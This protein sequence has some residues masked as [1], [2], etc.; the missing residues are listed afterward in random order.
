[1]AL[2]QQTRAQLRRRIADIFGD[3]RVIE[4]T[5]NG[6]AS[7]FID[8]FNVNS[9]T[10]EYRK[11]EILFTSGVNAGLASVITNTN[12]TNGTLTFTPSRSSTST[13]DDAEL[14]KIKG[15]GFSLAEYHRAIND[16][17]QELDGI[18]LIDTTQ[19]VALA[20]DA[21]TQTFLV[22]ASIR[23]VYRVEYEDAAGSWQELRPALR[24][25]QMG[26]TPEPGSGSIRV[27]GYGAYA[28]DGMDLR[29]WGYGL[30]EP[31][32]SD[33]S[34]CYYDAKAVVDIAAANLC[35]SRIDREPKYASL[36][37]TLMKRAEESKARARVLRD[38]QSQL[39][40]A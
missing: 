18:A 11:C 19:A 29:V 21:A 6:T 35:T 13:G 8:T 24:A 28:A 20:Y 31:L 30:Q 17:I 4:A 7:T 26:W 22:P 10:E 27:E 16:A 36:L 9:G 12:T 37:L 38:H 25:G 3:L 1:M 40:R 14:Y 15:T 5:A 32:S 39:V 33:A 2:I 34:I 23:E